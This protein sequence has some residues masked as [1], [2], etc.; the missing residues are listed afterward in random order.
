MTE[1]CFFSRFQ[2]LR[3][4]F[5]HLLEL[6]K[7]DGAVAVEVG[8]LDGS[9]GDAPQLLLRHLQAQHGSQHLHTRLLVFPVLHEK[10]Y[11]CSLCRRCT[12]I[13]QSRSGTFQALRLSDGFSNTVET[14]FFR[15]I[16]ESNLQKLLSGDLPVSVLIVELEGN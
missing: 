7:G 5:L 6:V 14:F 2:T 4:L 9:L 11:V 12:E 15:I 8:L 1:V 13:L 3:F 16:G 10:P